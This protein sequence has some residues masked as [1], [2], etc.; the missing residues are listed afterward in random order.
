M[1]LFDSVPRESFTLAIQRAEAAEAR[2]VKL[3][4]R[5]DELLKEHHKLTQQ[6]VTMRRRHQMDAKTEVR[7][8][9]VPKDTALTDQA[10]VAEAE[11]A[12]IE[13]AVADFVSKGADPDAAR[14]EAKRIRREV[15][16]NTI[17][18]GGI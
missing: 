10:R 5:Y 9:F 12:F 16:S 8:P 6:M 7:Q 4:A 11:D 1:A 18:P 3:Q 14:A 13:R 15:R 2:E 17:D